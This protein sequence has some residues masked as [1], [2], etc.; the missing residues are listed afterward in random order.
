M[1]ALPV[2]ADSL[3]RYMAEVRKFPLLSIEEERE[4]G[5]RVYENGDREAA[6]KLITANLRFVV[7]IANEYRHYGLSMVDLIQE[8]NIGLMKAVS[9]FNPH[10]GFRLISYG[11]WW[12]RAYIQAHVIKSWSLVKIGTTQAQRKLF[13]KLR[14]TRR[15]LAQVAGEDPTSAQ[16]A[17]ALG[18]EVSVVDEM[19]V[20]LAGRDFFLDSAIDSSE[21]E[22]GRTTHLERL[23]SAA[24]SQEEEM[25]DAQE[26]EKLQELAGEALTRLT[27]KERFVLERRVMSDDPLTLQEIGDHFHISRERARQIEGNA[28]RKVKKF[29]GEKTGQ[30][31][32]EATTVVEVAPAPKKQKQKKKIR[33]KDTVAA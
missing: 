5:R 28:L 26:S 10:R 16:L 18:V 12:I 3:S 25:S 32:V 30:E 6:Q 20:R 33:T 11:V 19:S 7:K 24:P 23:V 29:L 17:A 22:G 15:E 9:K 8:G 13:Y 14:K 2:L 31:I 27:E 21:G 4:L 1:S